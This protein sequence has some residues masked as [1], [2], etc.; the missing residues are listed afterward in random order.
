M[1]ALANYIERA[2]VATT[3][4]S[5]IREQS[6][7]VRPPRALWVPF[8]LGRPL[9]TSGDTEFQKDVMR[10]AFGLLD[11]TS[12]P[13]IVDYPNEAPPEGDA[14]NWVCPVSF[15]SAPADNIKDR[16]LAEVARL[17]PWSAET[18]RARGRTLFGVTGAPM[19]GVQRVAQALGDIADGGDVVN[20]P[21]VG[22]QWAFEMPLLIRH[23]VDD[24]RTFY[25]E[26][27]AAQPGPSAPNHEALNEW[28][29]G[30]TALGEALQATARHLTANDTTRAKFVRGLVIPEGFY[31]GGSAFPESR[32]FG[33]SG[34]QD[35]RAEASPIDSRSNPAK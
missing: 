32:E 12:E 4:V 29:F 13:T 24:L 23:I 26:A 25:H 3:S 16:L 10:A 11:S 18:R 27:I 17:A 33:A 15:S 34:G 21:D 22:I 1:G 5:L 14:E 6:E 31:N 19:D 8:A 30:S 2:G 9:G 35:D 20:P 28:I 7:A